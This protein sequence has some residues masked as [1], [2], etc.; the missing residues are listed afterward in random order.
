L[1]PTTNRPHLFTVT[2]DEKFHHPLARYGQLS[3]PEPAYWLLTAGVK[4]DFTLKHACGYLFQMSL[5]T[6]GGRLS[7]FQVGS[8][9]HDHILWMA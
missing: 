5:R 7:L 8:G 1:E 4:K 2:D 3:G 9:E 6:S